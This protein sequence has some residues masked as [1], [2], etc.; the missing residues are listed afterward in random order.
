M[1]LCRDLLHHFVFKINRTLFGSSVGYVPLS[2]RFLIMSAMVRMN[3]RT[4]LNRKRM[5][6]LCLKSNQGHDVG[7]RKR[8]AIDIFDR[9]IVR[10][11]VQ[12]NTNID[13]YYHPIKAIVSR[14]CVRLSVCY[15][16]LALER[17]RNKKYK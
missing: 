4:V 16:L 17:G 9:C 11:I 2:F 13:T 6:L 1:C 12:Y 3:V 14:V 8:D 7:E 15:N 5:I 10:T